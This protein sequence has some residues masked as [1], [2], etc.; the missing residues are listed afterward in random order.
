MHTHNF[1]DDVVGVVDVHAFSSNKEIPCVVLTC[2]GFGD[3]LI[4][5]RLTSSSL[6][7]NNARL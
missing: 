2:V 3:K 7:H 6:K 5:M 1:M 4:L